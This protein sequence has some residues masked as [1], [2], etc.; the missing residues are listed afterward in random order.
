MNRAGRRR[1]AAEARAEE[2]WDARKERWR[3]QHARLWWNY[4]WGRRR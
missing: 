4:P 3:Q 1:A 2:A